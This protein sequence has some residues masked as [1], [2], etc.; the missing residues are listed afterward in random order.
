MLNSHGYK[1]P[2]FLPRTYASPPVWGPDDCGTTL[3]FDLRASTAMVMVPSQLPLAALRAW[4][5]IQEPR[6]TDSR[7]GYSNR[8][9]PLVR[10]GTILE[11]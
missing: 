3:M 9:H 8:R 1:D 10:A 5:D 6:D 7:F 11:V 2:H 4:E